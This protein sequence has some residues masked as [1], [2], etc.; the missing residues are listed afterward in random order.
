MCIEWADRLPHP[1]PGAVSVR[2]TD[3]GEDTRELVITDESG[4]LTA[5]PGI[6]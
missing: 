5:D 1:L 6:S 3:Q 2:I 4:R